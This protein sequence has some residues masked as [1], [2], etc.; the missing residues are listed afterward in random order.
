[1]AS[2]FSLIGAYPD[3]KYVWGYFPECRQYDIDELMS[4]K[5][6]SEKTE[7]LWSGRMIDWKHPED[8]IE[9][10]AS[11]KKQGIPFHLTMVGGGVM[12][13]VLKQ[14]VKE[15]GLSED[16]EFTGFLKPEEV[17][18]RMEKADIYLFTS[19]QREGWGA[20]LN[21]SM[22]SGC[23]VIASSAIG[24]VPFMLDHCVNG[25]VYKS[26]RVRELA[27][28]LSK[29]AESRSLREKLGKNAYVT[30]RDVW[31]A[32]NAATG[33]VKELKRLAS[34]QPAT[35]DEDKKRSL[36]PMDKAPVISPLS[37]YGFVRRNRT[38]KDMKI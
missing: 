16:V 15:K 1:M 13:D 2:D 27:F 23:C 35:G 5:R 37:G 10:V 17:R 3:K 22:N 11:L 30:I 26:G 19:D 25:L 6:A 4:K 20:V 38:D 14:T 36:V 12:E 33:F 8:A 28:F 7:I 24:A 31:N 9:A 21:E 29:A 18:S 34:G 32:D